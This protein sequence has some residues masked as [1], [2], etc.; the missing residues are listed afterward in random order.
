[1]FLS[2]HDTLSDCHLHQR[3]LKHLHIHLVVSLLDT[4]PHPIER[5]MDVRH[6]ETNWYIL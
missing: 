3:H 5:Y 4:H 2:Q 1:M 6:D